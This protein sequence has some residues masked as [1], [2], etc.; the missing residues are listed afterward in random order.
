MSLEHG[1]V[2]GINLSDSLNYVSIGIGLTGL[3][4]IVLSG[5]NVRLFEHGI[6]LIFS[7]LLMTL[8]EDSTFI[9]NIEILQSESKM[10]G[11]S[12]RV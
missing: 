4:I 12:L 9:Q 10:M 2:A 11:C 7:F 3:F 1:R 8:G 5:F 6:G